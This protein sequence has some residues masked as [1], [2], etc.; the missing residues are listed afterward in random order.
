MLNNQINFLGIILITTAL[1]L[2]AVPFVRP[3]LFRHQDVLL[4]M[5]FLICGF[6]LLFQNR[7][8][9]QEVTQY[10]L[11]LLMFP[12]IFYSFESLRLRNKKLKNK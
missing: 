12:A 5:A 1:C 7:F 2:S 11:I 4:I 3:N 10:N 8:Y 6:I 9:T